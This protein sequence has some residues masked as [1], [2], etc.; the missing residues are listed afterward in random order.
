MDILSDKWQSEKINGIYNLQVAIFS[1][2]WHL[3]VIKEYFHLLVTI[4][5]INGN[6]NF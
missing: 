6:K 4:A 5:V 3:P 1:Y 2:Q